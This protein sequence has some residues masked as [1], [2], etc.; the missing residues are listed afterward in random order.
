MNKAG[1]ST[2]EM[3]NERRKMRR[4][5]AYSVVAISIAGICVILVLM[6]YDRAIVRTWGILGALALMAAMLAVKFLLDRIGNSAFASM[7]FLHKRNRM[8]FE[9]QREKK[10]LDKYSKTSP[11]HGTSYSMT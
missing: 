7:D 9:E 5:T 2:R 4:L 6:A 10:K 1:E 11:R 3:A 8:Q